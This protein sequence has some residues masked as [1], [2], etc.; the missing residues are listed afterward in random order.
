MSNWKNIYV[1]MP[2]RR[3]RI[4]P[5]FY[6]LLAA[7]LAL[8]FGLNCAR[9]ALRIHKAQL[10][11]DALQQQCAAQEARLEELEAAI[12]YA[13]TDDYVEKIARSE[14]NLLYPGEIR[15]IAG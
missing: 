15:Y 13:Q 5:R 7:V 9:I 1:H 12:A 4:R 2:R 10:R 6:L 8:A 3:F 14:L 11:I